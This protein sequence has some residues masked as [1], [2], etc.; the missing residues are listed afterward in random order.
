M[1]LP[2]TNH[3]LR[4]V[5]SE[6]ESSGV[7]TGLSARMDCGVLDKTTRDVG[8]NTSSSGAS[9]RPTSGGGYSRDA[10]GKRSRGSA[11]KRGYSFEFC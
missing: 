2:G 10:L 3:T 8:F 11:K 5:K 4:P 9:G 6:S 1:A 7:S